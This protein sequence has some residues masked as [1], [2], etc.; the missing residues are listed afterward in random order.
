M[1]R[2]Y[3]SGFR[4]QRLN[5][6]HARYGLDIPLAGMPFPTVEYDRGEAV[7]LVNYY[8]RDMVLPRGLNVAAALKAARELRGPMGTVLP[9]ITVQYDP[10]NWSMQVFGHNDPARDLLGSAEWQAVTEEHFVRLLYRLRGRHLP[11]LTPFGVE[12]STAPW[13]RS[14]GPLTPVDWPCQDMSRRRRAYEPEGNGVRFSMRNPCADIDFA[15]VGS[16]SGAVELLVDYK[17]AGAYVDPGHLT[18][19]A[20]AGLSRLDGS[21]IP[22]MIVTY[23]PGYDADGSLWMFEVHCLN[24][25]AENLLIGQ[26]AHGVQPWNTLTEAEYFGMLDGASAL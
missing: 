11:D 3:D 8:R 15:A 14:D 4:D 22:S 16:R 7:A 10:R 21:P 26:L 19:N 9:L 6:I 23:Q 18:H 17:M 5:L 1:A 2:K 24:E 25:A 13:Q 12:L 20:M